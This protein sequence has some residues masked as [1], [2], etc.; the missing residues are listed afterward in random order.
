MGVQQSYNVNPSSGFPGDVARPSE[1]HG[2]DSGI[3]I[4]PSGATRKPRPGDAVYY[5]DTNNGF[6][7]PTTAAQLL[8]VCGILSYRADQVARST[9]ILEFNNG[10]EIE[11]GVFGT[12]W[13]KA[14]S[15]IEYDDLIAWDV[16]TFDWASLA[17]PAAFA[18]LVNYPIT[19]VS[20]LA[21][22]ANGIAQARVGFGRI[23]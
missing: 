4:V 13:V 15:A 18:N 1:P 19:C 10:D 12:F 20:R 9:S 14:K 6:A 21:V 22:A 11:V 5:D 3:I 23:K 17:A 16:A 7:I 8:T 2:L